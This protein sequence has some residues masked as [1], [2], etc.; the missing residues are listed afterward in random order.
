MINNYEYMK[1]NIRKEK[2]KILRNVWNTL[3]QWIITKRVEI[4]H[5]STKT[6][7]KQMKFLFVYT[8]SLDLLCRKQTRRDLDWP[9]YW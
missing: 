4:I 6:I 1:N 7:T 8:V 3:D 2:K 9:V 5:L